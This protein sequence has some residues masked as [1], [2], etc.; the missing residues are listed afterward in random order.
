MALS[1]SSQRAEAKVVAVW[2]AAGSTGRSSIAAA[3]ACEL[4]K[5]SKRVLLIDCDVVA[6]AQLQVFGFDQHHSGINAAVRL[7]NQGQLD[8]Q[9]LS[10]LL[11]DFDFEKARLQL[12]PG[13]S[14]VNRWQQLSFESIRQLIAFCR[15]GFDFVVLDLASSLEAKVI[16]LESQVE[17]NGAT[18]AALAEADHLVA[19]TNSDVV[20][21]NRFIWAV[22][23][24]KDLKLESKLHVV[25]NRVDHSA[26]GRA[27][28]AEIAQTI[29]NFVALPVAV[30]LSNDDQLFGRAIAEGVPITQVRKNSSVKQA[31]RQFVLSEL[32]E[33]PSNSRRHV[34]KL[35]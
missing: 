22:D 12:L 23:Q 28:T 4:A 11:L 34:A 25:A 3:I 27:T 6:P 16:H 24:L 10:N 5:H 14:M 20:S 18:L 21:L 26:V 19:I 32:L 29:H 13:L 31:L 33:L 9:A 1:V 8:W 2:S 15:Q 30:F 7:Q 35:G 17:R